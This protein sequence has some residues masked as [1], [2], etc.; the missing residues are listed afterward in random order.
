MR[1]QK[2]TVVIHACVVTAVVMLALPAEAQKAPATAGGRGIVAGMAA[3][4]P[5]DGHPRFDRPPVAAGAPAASFGV[6]E[7]PGNPPLPVVAPL[8]SGSYVNFESPPVKALALS[9]DGLRLFVANTAAD[10]LDVVRTGVATGEPARVMAQI[11]VGIQPVSV[12]VQPGTNGRIVWVANF[13][14]DDISV[15]DTVAGVVLDVI[16]VGDEP[17]NVVFDDSGAFAFVVLQ[18]PSVAGQLAQDLRPYVVTIDAAARQVIAELPLEMLAARAAAYDAEQR[19]LIVAALHGGNNTSLLGK[20][21]L[22]V[23]DTSDPNTPF[24]V[25]YTLQLLRDFSVT[26]TAFANSSLAPWPDPSAQPNQPFVPRIVNDAGVVDDWQDVIAP[27]LL[28][29]GQIDPAVASQFAVEMAPQFGGNLIL[30]ATEVLQEIVADVP[31]TVDHDLAVIDVSD[32][33]APQVVQYIGDVGTTM[34]A[35]ALQPGRDRVLVA[36]LEPR[37]LVKFEHNLRGHIVDHEIVAVSQLAGGASVRTFD[38]HAGIPGFNNGAPGA[39]AFSLAD[40]KDIVIN[41][42]G[43]RA[44]IAAM[45]PGRVG[46]LDAASGQVLARLDVGRGPRSLALDEAHKRLY[47]F[48]RTDLSVAVV[49][50]ASD[51]SPQLLTTVYLFN[52]EPPAVKLGRDFLYST[53]FSANFASSC[54]VCHIDAGLDH[55]AW[56]LGDP[57]GPMQ[58]VPDNLEPLGLENHPVKGPMVT[59]SLRGLRDHNNL[60]WRGDRPTFADF[61]P[62]FDKLLG[63]SELTDAQMDAF[64]AFIETVVYPPNPYLNRDNSPKN[65]R[66]WDGAVVYLN[67]CQVCHQVEH[68]GALRLAGV[69]DDAGIELG[70]VFG[71]IQ[72]VT[73]LRGIHRKFNS[74]LFGGF[75]LIHDGREERE[76]RSHPMETFF[77]TFF[78]FLTPQQRSDLIAFLTA[79]QTNV[80][81]IVGWQVRVAV[82][83][84]PAQRAAIDQMIAQSEQVPSHNDVIAL[85]QVAGQQR[86]FWLIPGGGGQFMADDGTVQDLDSLLASLAPGDVLVF[87]AVAPGSGRR[88][89]IDWDLDCVLNAFDPV[90]RGTSDLNGDTFVDLVDLSTLLS[91]FGSQPVPREQGDIDGDGDVD[92]LDLA[93]LLGDF[94]TQCAP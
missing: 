50:I 46:V 31:D 11:P 80:T 18:G 51:T 23:L 75:G 93:L 24:Q 88:L 87:E 77:D 89:G 22:V 12:A 20:Q 32:P 28:P 38:L 54:A 26:A 43:T 2:P 60:H 82:P 19:R 47:V 9:D 1:R 66:V 86:G 85:G 61:N 13:I 81:N 71:Q 8:A 91:H 33:A 90:P 16:E 65:P 6:P 42:D 67:N 58:P 5:G 84:G 30:N 36:N 57:S 3:G 45:G 34:S 69:E 10:T 52:P 21:V 64:T 7:G 68:D 94:G 25:G 41:A 48:N 29:D 73:Q 92:L 79:F 27:L 72:L 78:S 44:Y 63:G 62:A 55:L 17:V 39:A 70:G 4:A 56:D 35:M 40:P 15:V 74:D 83:V 53:R 37:N 76:H 14:S 59:L 49:D